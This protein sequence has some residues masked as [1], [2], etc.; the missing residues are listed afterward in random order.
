MK[1]QANYPYRRRRRFVD[2]MIQGKL[3]FGLIIIESLLFTAGMI[4]IYNDLQSALQSS[5]YRVHQ[6]VDSGRPLLL[7]ELL[8]IFP[9]IIAANLA[10]V[11][12]VDRRWKRV[13]RQIIFQLQDI[14]YRVKRLDLR[15]YTI[16]HTDH[17]VLQT[18]KQWLDKERDR[19]ASLQARVHNLPEKINIENTIELHQVRENLK[20]A[21]RLL[22]DS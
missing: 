9:W 19:N 20:S 4:F 3:L 17:E 10:L 2:K 16:K 8:I 18:A 5:M 14:L 21:A 13:V 1:N 6:D 12:L 22:P 7:K 15:A 11:V